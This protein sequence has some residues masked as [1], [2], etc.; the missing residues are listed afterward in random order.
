MSLE[1]C[2]RSRLTSRGQRADTLTED[3]PGPGLWGNRERTTGLGDL[4]RVS[5]ELL[6]S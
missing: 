3:R 5:G 4:G 6:K 1:A 2:G